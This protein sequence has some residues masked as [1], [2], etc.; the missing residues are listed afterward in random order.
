MN[1]Q[2]HIHSDIEIKYTIRMLSSIIVFGGNIIS[3]E[4]EYIKLQ[5]RVQSKL[6]VILFKWISTLFVAVVDSFTPIALQ[7]RD[8]PNKEEGKFYLNSIFS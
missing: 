8:S 5:I 1:I 6:Q 7:T 3:S 4:D 2:M